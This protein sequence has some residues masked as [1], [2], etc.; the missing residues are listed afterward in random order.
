MAPT[1]RLGFIP[2][3]GQA[4]I[5]DDQL[6]HFLNFCVGSPERLAHLNRHAPYPVPDAPAMRAFLRAAG[7]TYRAWV[8]ERANDRALVGMV[9]HGDFVPGCSNSVGVCI[10]LDYVRN[11]Y[12]SEAI[13]SLCLTLAAEGNPRVM[14]YCLAGNHPCERMLLHC[15]FQRLGA[16]GRRH[17][18]QDE[19][20]FQFSNGGKGFSA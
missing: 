10:G 5:H 1:Q 6:D 15:G 3:F 2:T 11:G 7:R 14:A 18:G 12:G 16:T 17:A 13:Q 9:I 8:I 19:V 4:A 20:R